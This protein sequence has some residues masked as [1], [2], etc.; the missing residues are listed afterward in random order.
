M[1]KYTSSNCIT[2]YLKYYIVFCTRYRRKLFTDNDVTDKISELISDV[3]VKE[4]Y[5]LIN[6]SFGEDYVFIE[7]LCQTTVSPR[8]LMYQFKHVCNV[9]E[10]KTHFKV[11]ENMPNVWTR[12]GIISTKEIPEEV[13]KHYIS[14]VK[15]RS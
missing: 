5:E 12:G 4:K 14:S 1:E 9:R 6:L 7:V 10:L 11:F 3:C 2:F 15:K 8:Q 13:R